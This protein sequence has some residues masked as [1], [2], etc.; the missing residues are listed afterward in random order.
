MS[1]TAGGRPTSR[2]ETGEI[3]EHRWVS[4]LLRQVAGADQGRLRIAS[5]LAAED[6]RR[7]WQRTEHRASSRDRRTHQVCCQELALRGVLDQIRGLAPRQAPDA[8]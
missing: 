1:S 5:T 6:L 3:G 4:D 2:P 7:I 8:I